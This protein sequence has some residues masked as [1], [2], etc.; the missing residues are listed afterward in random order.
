MFAECLYDGC[1]KGDA[2]IPTTAVA[3]HSLTHPQSNAPTLIHAPPCHG[4][5]EYAPGKLFMYGGLDAS[6]K[7]YND[8][9]VY[10]TATASWECVYA[11][12]SDLVVPTGSVATL[13]QVRVR[14]CELPSLLVANLF[15]VKHFN[16]ML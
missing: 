10:D 11:G 6:N 14:A 12:H 7:P 1:A 4:S 16:G 8:A 5:Q 2:G 9:W 3:P 15:C 13:M